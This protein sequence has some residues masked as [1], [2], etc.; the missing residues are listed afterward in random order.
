LRGGGGGKKEESDSEENHTQ[1]WS[2]RGGSRAFSVNRDNM[3][4]NERGE[5]VR[6]SDSEI[7]KRGGGGDKVLKWLEKSVFVI[8]VCWG[9]TMQAKGKVLRKTRTDH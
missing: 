3:E 2:G 9:D 4:L 1:G 7:R 5:F 6:F 8:K